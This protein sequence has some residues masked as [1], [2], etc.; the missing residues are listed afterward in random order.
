[1][2][3]AFW[4]GSKIVAVEVDGT[5]HIGDEKHITKDRMLQRAGVQVIHVLNKELV[6]HGTKVIEALLP[7]PISRYWQDLEEPRG[8]FLFR[9]E[10]NW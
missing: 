5:S 6:E 4:T 10:K 1:V 7:T 3:F 8:Y 2:D 9:F